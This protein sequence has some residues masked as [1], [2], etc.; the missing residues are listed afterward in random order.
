MEHRW[1]TRIA[2][3]LP[4]ELRREGAQ[5]VRARIEQLSLSGARLRTATVLPPFARIEVM[6]GEQAIPAWI[7]R[8]TTGGFGIE[9]GQFAP[10]V[11]ATILRGSR[12]ERNPDRFDEPAVAAN[13]AA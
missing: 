5:S 10:A 11:V 6:I 4:V 12:L 1:G 2:I 7:V 8:R 3:S 9:W 13:R